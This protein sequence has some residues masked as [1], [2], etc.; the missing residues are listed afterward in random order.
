LMCRWLSGTLTVIHPMAKS[1]GNMQLQLKLL[2]ELEPSEAPPGQLHGSP[3][4]WQLAGPVAVRPAAGPAADAAAAA[5]KPAAAVANPAAASE[6]I[7][8]T[9][10]EATSLEEEATEALC[11]N[12]CTTAAVKADLQPEQQE[13]LH[14]ADVAVL[15]DK[16]EAGPTAPEQSALLPVPVPD[17]VVRDVSRGRR[18]QQKPL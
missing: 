1:L 4:H 14:S 3:A 11:S 10:A 2:L 17:D 16:T 18:P 5:A 9:P 7:A 12:T 8:Q 13:L 6:A 15:Q